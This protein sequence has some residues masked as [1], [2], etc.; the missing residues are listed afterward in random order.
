[1]HLGFDLPVR[2]YLVI[3]IEVVRDALGGDGAAVVDLSDSPAGQ[4][5]L[6]VTRDSY[7]YNRQTTQK[8]V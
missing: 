4:E 6:V 5:Y 3:D 2:R 1:M 7:S 8:L